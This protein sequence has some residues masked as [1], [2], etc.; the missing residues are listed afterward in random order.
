MRKIFLVVVMMVMA[1]TVFAQSDDGEAFTVSLWVSIEDDTYRTRVYNEVVNQLRSSSE[2]NFE[3]D[4]ENTGSTDIHLV[5]SGMKVEGSQRYAWSIAFTP[6]FM[7]QFNNANV[8]ISGANINGMNWVARRSVEFVEGQLYII[9]DSVQEF[10]RENTVDEP[11]EDV[12]T[13]TSA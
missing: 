11:A 4:Q 13:Q 3:L 10:D 7:P 12:E 1:F 8:A 9:L 6:N 5:I 2:W